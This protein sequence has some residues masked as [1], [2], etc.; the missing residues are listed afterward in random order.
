MPFDR[1]EPAAWWQGAEAAPPMPVEPGP[2]ALAATAYGW[3]WRRLEER[4]PEPGL[5]ALAAAVLARSGGS[6]QPR[7]LPPPAPVPDTHD[8]DTAGIIRE[9]MRALDR[10]AT[11]AEREAEGRRAQVRCLIGLLAPAATQGGVRVSNVTAGEIV[12]LLLEL[13][14]DAARPLWTPP[15]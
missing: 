3:E 7:T 4:V 10:L 11:H 9:G 2:W 14:P 12:R 8:A 1:T 6:G 5:K 13:V 15:G